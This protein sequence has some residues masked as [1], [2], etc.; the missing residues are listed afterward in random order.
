MEAV[1]VVLRLIM[2]MQDMVELVVT[3]LVAA[4]VVDLIMDMEEMVEMVE[5]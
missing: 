1:A 5:H 4:V 3:T 2:V